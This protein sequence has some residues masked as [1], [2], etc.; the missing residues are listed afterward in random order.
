LL[1]EIMSDGTFTV[2]ELVQELSKLDPKLVVYVCTERDESI[3]PCASIYTCVL[4][5]EKIVLIEGG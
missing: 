4:N 1:E 3:L 5:E 2:G